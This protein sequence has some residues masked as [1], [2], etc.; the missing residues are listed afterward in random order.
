MSEFEVSAERRNET[1]KGAMRRLRRA[2]R[3]PGVV[4]GAGTDPENITVKDNELRKQIAG[5][6]YRDGGYPFDVVV[7]P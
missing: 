6:A 5:I 3:V 2:G 7:K 1:G 4:Y